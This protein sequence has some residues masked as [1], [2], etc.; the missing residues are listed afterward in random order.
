MI[1]FFKN[2]S[3][4]T[5]LITTIVFIFIFIIFVVFISA[6]L[7]RSLNN[8]QPQT[9]LKQVEITFWT[10]NGYINKEALEEIISNFEKENPNI[11]I[12]H[13]FQSD[14]N[15]KNRIIT[16][17]KNNTGELADVIE[18]DENWLNQI[19]IYVN[20]IQDSNII[21]KY[22]PAIV[23]N[24]SINSNLYAIPFQFDSILLAYNT[25]YFKSK[26]ITQKDINKLDWTDLALKAKEHTTT[27]KVSKNNIEYQKIKKSGIAVGSPITVKNAK[28]I[29]KLLIIQNNAN[30]YDNLENK[31]NYNNK[32]SDVLDFY[33]NFSKKN[34]WS[35]ELGDDIT[36]FAKEDVYMVFVRSSDIDQIKKINP[37][38]KFEVTITP[39]ISIMKSISLS[40]SLIIP[41]TSPHYKE[42]LKFIDYLTSK[43]NSIKLFNSKSDYTFIP[44]QVDSLN[45]IPKDS[46]FSTYSDLITTSEKFKSHDEEEFDKVLNNYLISIYQRANI[47]SKN[48]IL[49][50]NY[51]AKELINNLNIAV[52]NN[53]NNE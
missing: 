5:K 3:K 1:D 14:T 7:I 12:K 39:K 31:Y 41:K 27:E 11:K 37:N 25:D 29:L 51:N 46:I 50:F 15:Y 21:D 48:E 6:I 19:Y 22:S 32:L 35:N 45:E 47:G 17:L 4:Q 8:Q 16:R 43:E 20:P 9:P 18:I 52:D 49:E 53:K 30:I 24:N 23:E 13:E 38:L 36:A 28:E 42:S 10:R 33:F 2:A 34:I 26:G 40:K 44:A